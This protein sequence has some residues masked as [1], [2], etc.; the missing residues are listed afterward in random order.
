MNYDTFVYEYLQYPA[1]IGCHQSSVIEDGYVEI[2]Y[3]VFKK[4]ILK[5]SIM[6]KNFIIKG[7]HA[8]LKAFV[9]EVGIRHH[10]PEYIQN[11]ECLSGFIGL[12]EKPL[13]MSCSKDNYDGPVNEFELPLQWNKAIE[14]VKKWYDES[15]KVQFNFGDDTFEIKYDSQ[16]N[17]IAVSKNYNHGYKDIIDKNNLKAVIDY[18]SGDLK[19]LGENMQ[20]VN[21]SPWYIKFGK[22]QGTLNE[23]KKIY[24]ALCK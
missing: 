7:S 21:K 9:E 18:F 3:E 4:L 17:K 11:F 22:Y 10:A 23:L 24:T 19:L 2:S 20:I 13:L 5:Q 8:L 12:N 15:T 6:N 1:Y 14:Y 16:N